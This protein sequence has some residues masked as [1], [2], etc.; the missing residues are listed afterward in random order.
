MFYG[1]GYIGKQKNPPTPEEEKAEKERMRKERRKEII[2]TA[3]L[4]T[5]LLPVLLLVAVVCFLYLGTVMCWEEIKERKKNGWKRS[6]KDVEKEEKWEPRPKLLSHTITT[7]DHELPALFDRHYVVYVETEYNQPLNS[8]ICN[9]MEYI[10]K[11]FLERNYHF[12]YIP[13][14][15]NLSDED[16][17]C[18]FPLDTASMTDEIRN[19]IRNI[20]TEQ[21]T[22]MFL[23]LIGMDFS[24]S[25][26]GLMS[27][28][29]YRG[30]IGHRIPDLDCS[31]SHFVYVDLQ[32]C[33]PDNIKEAFEEY[34]KFY[35]TELKTGVFCARPREE[36]PLDDWQEGESGG[37]QNDVPD[38]LFYYDQQKMLGI[39]EEIRQRVEILRQGGY[40]E[41]LL[42]TLGADLVKQIKD[43]RKTATPLMHLNISDNLRIFIPELDNREM[44]MPALAR[45]LY[46]FYLR[47]EEGVEF[48]FLSE[49]TEELFSLYRLASNRLDDS[50]LRATVDSLVNPTENKINECVSRIKTAFLSVMD[51]YAARNY[52]LQMR[53]KEFRRE[54][55]EEGKVKLFK[56]MAKYISLPRHLVSYPDAVR[57]VPVIKGSSFHDRTLM[58]ED[59]DRR[60]DRMTEVVNRFTNLDNNKSFFGRKKRETEKQRL[61]S[62][63]VEASMAVLEMQPNNFL[64]HFNLGEA[65]CNAVD[66][67]KS[68]HENTML[69]EHDA[70][71]WNASYINR[72]EAYLY[73]GE[74]DKGLA[75][76]DSYF[77]SLR[78]WKE[79]DEEADRIK[80]L[81]MKAK[82]ES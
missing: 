71:T 1:Y 31:E 65:Y 17:A 51:E 47:H 60:C 26:A 59:F 78:R 48:K 44:K 33:C 30:D 66:F 77:N 55:P 57:Q 37:H 20:T 67:D 34:F 2:G 62:E 43:S 15:K 23:S 25:K 63:L 11:G 56:D 38:F 64:A 4:H 6:K 18:A 58:E 76:I 32:N 52:C 12:V 53:N 50:R 9:N 79:G 22:H 82:V 28:H 7:C 35:A 68:I 5:L 3:I 19:N 14:L 74:Y 69:I 41:L 42:H 27:L 45:A 16:L 46:V 40:I 10:R 73:A 21:F 75:D 36:Y 49:F 29:R 80:A 81:L 24:G 13:E 72:A 70:Y 8:F 54:A 61:R 39:A